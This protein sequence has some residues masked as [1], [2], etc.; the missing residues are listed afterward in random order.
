MKRQPLRSKAALVCNWIG[1]SEARFFMA[2]F[3]LATIVLCSSLLGNLNGQLGDYPVGDKGTNLW[4][5]WWVFYSVFQEGQSPLYSDMI[6]YPWGCDLRYH[7]LSVANGIIASPMTWLLGPSMAYNILFLLW[8]WLTGVGAAL[9]GRSLGLRLFGA[10]LLGI[11][12]SFS[13]YRW[14]H[15]EHLNLFS[16]AWMFF[17]F[18]AFEKWMDDQRWRNGVYFT[19]I[20]FLAGLTDWYYGLFVA[21]YAFVRFFLSAWEWWDKKKILNLGIQCALACFAMGILVWFYF[22]PSRTS[23]FQ[24]VY[25]DPVD[26]KYSIYWSMDLMS[27]FFPPWLVHWI[28]WFDVPKEKEFFIHPGMVL[29]VGTWFFIL[30]GWLKG[31]TCCWKWRALVLLA[32][33]FLLLSLGPMLKVNEDLPTILG[34]PLVL[35]AIVF[36]GLP[37]LTVLRVFARFSYVGF[38]ALI[39]VGIMGMERSPWYSRRRTKIGLLVFLLPIFLL[40]TGWK[41]LPVFQFDPHS[42]RFAGNAETVLVL[43]YTPSPRSGMHMYYQTFHQKPIYVV[44]FS[45]LRRYKQQYLTAYP[46]LPYL[47]QVTLPE[48]NRESTLEIEGMELC[49]ELYKLGRCKIIFEGEFVHEERRKQMISEIQRIQDQCSQFQGELWLNIKEKK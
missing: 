10:G 47:N 20:W 14:N 41:P 22:S 27:I 44:E 6:F 28:P 7:T 45:R 15:L 37:A 35:P 30:W 48:M 38:L 46:I 17:A 5:L 13:P 3:F 8:T 23:S 9:W 24:E 19:L 25:V 49:K 31:R 26:L 29:F 34:F 2:I 32:V 12:A 18:Y 4:N 16:T 11:I 40:E 42:E 36:E 21:I 39:A 33:V 1:R 43:P